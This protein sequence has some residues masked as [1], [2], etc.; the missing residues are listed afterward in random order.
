MSVG[1]QPVE[2]L[3]CYCY[4]V[5][6]EQIQRSIQTFDTQTVEEVA[7]LTRA[8]TGCT[9]CHCRIR[10][11]LAGLPASCTA[12]MCVT[13]GFHTSDCECKVA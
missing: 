4:D 7:R 13:C 12:E 10:R 3:V 9:A 2:T 6:E 8:G 5:T 11:M 1:Q